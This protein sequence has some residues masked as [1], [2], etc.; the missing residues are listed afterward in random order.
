MVSWR[1][2]S[3]FSFLVRVRKQCP[4][5][6]RSV[7]QQFSPG[8]LTVKR[9][10]TP[11]FEEKTSS[12]HPPKDDGDH[13]S[14]IDL[15]TLRRRHPCPPLST[16]VSPPLT[17]SDTEQ[18]ETGRTSYPEPIQASQ[19]QLA[20]PEG[21]KSRT[22]ILSKEDSDRRI[23]KEDSRAK[24]TSASTSNDLV[25][26]EEHSKQP[27][28]TRSNFDFTSTTMDPY[29][30]RYLDQK[31]SPRSKSMPHTKTPRLSEQRRSREDLDVESLRPTD[32]RSLYMRQRRGSENGE[33]EKIQ[34]KLEH[35][36]GEPASVPEESVD[37]GIQQLKLASSGNSVVI[38]RSVLTHLIEKTITLSGASLSG[39]NVIIEKYSPTWHRFARLLR[40]SDLHKISALRDPKTSIVSS[41]TNPAIQTKE[42]QASDTLPSP[43]LNEPLPNSEPSNI[44]EDIRATRERE[45]VILSLDSKRKK[46]I[47]SRFRRLFN[48]LP[49][50]DYSTPDSLLTVESLNKYA[51]PTEMLI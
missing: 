21:V 36:S 42:Q 40:T 37:V 46:V 33:D 51:R 15:I 39:D 16:I 13:D 31:E 23:E 7:S 47:S 49:Q 32:I 26:N 44:A 38:P 8:V 25:G 30:L 24:L 41:N 14:N 3:G 2:S 5:V 19:D 12:L 22:D 27:S 35:P 17:E 48:D 34:S 1:I 20:Q 11:V 4:Q 28:S 45:F 6:P 18:T 29:L 43:I 9:A 50:Q 10:A